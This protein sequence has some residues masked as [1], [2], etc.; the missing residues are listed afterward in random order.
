VKY[1]SLNSIELLVRKPKIDCEV[2]KERKVKKESK[3]KR[4]KT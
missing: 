3:G 4:A 1:W 2:R